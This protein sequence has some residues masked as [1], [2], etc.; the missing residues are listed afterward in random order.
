MVQ[1]HAANQDHA[2]FHVRQPMR[3]WTVSTAH[4]TA[5]CCFHAGQGLRCKMVSPWKFVVLMV[6]GSD[7]HVY[8]VKVG[9]RENQNQNHRESKM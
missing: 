2:L 6:D 5:L 9:K 7:E 4:S 8:S 1:C 3:W